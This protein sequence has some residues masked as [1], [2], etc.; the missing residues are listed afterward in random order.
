VPSSPLIE[1]DQ[2]IATSR[3]NPMDRTAIKSKRPCEF[4][5]RLGMI[6]QRR[7]NAQAVLSEAARPGPAELGSPLWPAKRI[8]PAT[9]CALRFP[10]RD[11]F[12]R[13]RCRRELGDRGHPWFRVA[14][15]CDSPR[16]QDV[17]RRAPTFVPA[18]A[19]LD[20]PG[21]NEALVRGNDT[22]AVDA[23]SF[24]DVA[25]P[26]VVLHPCDASSQLKVNAEHLG[27][28]TAGAPGPSGIANDCGYEGRPDRVPRYLARDLLHFRARQW[29][30]ARVS[31]DRH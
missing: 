11:D 31:I 23:R 17:R 25:Y 26:R 2:P 8:M 16:R 13:F 20:E 10:C 7:K 5:G 3:E 21:V 22:I 18:P 30:Y 14:E 6:D 9:E 4:D 28:S 12:C 24:R 27:V 29:R 1:G 19:S 15:Q